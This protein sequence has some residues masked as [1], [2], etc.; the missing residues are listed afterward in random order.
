MQTLFTTAQQ[1]LERRWQEQY[2]QSRAI[3]DGGAADAAFCAIGYAHFDIDRAEQ[4]LRRIF[5]AQQS[6]GLLLEADTNRASFSSLEPTPSSHFPSLRAEGPISLPVYGFVLWRLYEIADDKGRAKSFLREMYPLVMQLHRYLYEF[7]DP[8]EEG[9]VSI[10]YPSETDFGLASP[11]IAGVEG[12]AAASIGAKPRFAQAR[13]FF[14]PGATGGLTWIQDPLFNGLLAWSNECLIRIGSLLEEDVSEAIQWDELAKFAINEKLWD[15]ARGL[16]QAYN[17]LGEET[18][19]AIGLAALIPLCGEVPIQ[20]QAE[21]LLSVL[22]SPAFGGKRTDT[23]LCPSHPLPANELQNPNYHSCPVQIKYNWLLYHG[24][25]RY[26]MQ[27]MAAR[28]R[29]HSLELLHQYGCFEYF[30]P[31]RQFEAAFGN[32]PCPVAAALGL[33]FLNEG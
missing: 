9:L 18:I 23:F 19:P 20:E 8:L 13:A 4:I 7:R 11:E 28:L 2:A 12:H 3:P 14:P 24:L 27:Q 10:C 32:F 22:A 33:D 29:N 26:D 30:S 16:Y 25:L 31:Y 17:L 21:Q 6:S 15:E 1:V 5:S